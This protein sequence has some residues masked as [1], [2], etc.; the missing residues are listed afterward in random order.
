M[1]LKTVS[2]I[3]IGTYFE[4]LSQVKAGKILGTRVL[5]TSVF[6]P[7][8]FEFLFHYSAPVS[9]CALIEWILTTLRSL[10]MVQIV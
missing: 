9:P 8:V 5:Y 2:Y 1:Y 7:S 3:L 10:C 6:T 4:N